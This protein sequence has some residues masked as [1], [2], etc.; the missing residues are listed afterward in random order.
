M[1]LDVYT[2]QVTCA[3]VAFASVIIL[4]ALR[5]SNIKPVAVNHWL[6]GMCL[7]SP[8][9]LLLGFR[10]QI[11][12]LWSAVLASSAI[13]AGML[14]LHRGV[15]RF[16]GNPPRNRLD[17]TVL[18]GFVAVFM[19]FTYVYPHY[20]ARITLI[21]FVLIA[22]CLD[23]ARALY[24]EHDASW[25]TAGHAV[26]ATFLLLALALVSR[27]VT[28]L[29]DFADY[30]P[31]GDR[32][33][34]AFFLAVLFVVGA[35]TMTLTFLCLAEVSSEFRLFASAVSHCSS[36]IIITDAK[37]RV[38]YTNPGFEKK[39]GLT[40]EKLQ[41]S[42]EPYGFGEMNQD[43]RRELWATLGTGKTWRGE[44][45]TIGSDGSKRWEVTT[46]SPIRLKDG[47]VSHLVAVQED[48]SARKEAEDKIRQMAYHDALTGLP[49]LR[50]AKDRLNEACLL[51]SRT[52]TLVSVMFLDLDGFKAINDTFGHDAGDELL[53]E[54]S[55]RMQAIVR[56]SDTVARIGGD[57]F[58]ILLTSLTQTDG[59]NRVAEKIIQ[60]VSEP[61]HLSDGRQVSV[62]TS[63]GVA[64]YPTHGDS[65]EL[66]LKLADAAM[67]E[68]KRN[69]KNDYC[70]AA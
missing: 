57:E 25:R 11:G 58:L 6:A 35:I 24:K 23:T 69:G 33:A 29:Q 44:L 13:V 21:S 16:I 70:I 4:F 10:D 43:Q 46:I 65:S 64:F 26:S 60:I 56:E 62:G 14:L 37:G 7:L 1:I 9:L 53:I 2:L 19:F 32:A 39:T 34:G 22:I 55:K 42:T 38:T 54:V 20:A 17:L 12:L 5:L 61:I 27:E 48:I 67:Y 49:S 8:G 51:A 52:N 45:Q 68:V 18:V 30:S 40:L 63:I 31:I 15:H 41:K 3:L 66:V 47:T 59:V 28:I 36:S 50:L